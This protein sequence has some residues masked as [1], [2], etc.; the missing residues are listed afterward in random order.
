MKITRIKACNLASLAGVVE[1]DLKKGALA[2]AGLFAITGPTGSGKT[3]LLDA[4][5]LAL[6]DQTPRLQEANGRVK[7]GRAG[8]HDALSAQSPRSLLRHDAGSGYAEVDFESSE[9][10]PFCA[11][12]EVRRAGDKAS[13]RLQS[14]KMTLTDLITNEVMGSGTKTDTKNLI[15][16]HLGLN[17]DQ[18]TRSALLAQGQFASFLKAKRDERA[19]L[20]ER[21]TGTDLYARISEQAFA[22]NKAAKETL[23]T[24]ESRQAEL[25]LLTP[26]ERAAKHGILQEI[27]R[28]VEALERRQL[29]HKRHAEWT[30]RLAECSK[31][32][33]EAKA[34]AEAA[35]QAWDQGSEERARLERYE[36]AALQL[37][38]LAQ[39]KATQAKLQ[40]QGLQLASRRE[41]LKKAELAVAANETTLKSTL[42]ERTAARSRAEDLGPKIQRAQE[43]QGL[44]LAAKSEQ[45]DAQ[46]QL[47]ESSTQLRGA[48]REFSVLQDSV[49]EVQTQLRL[50]QDALAQ[51]AQAGSL[52]PI[53]PRVRKDLERAAALK[54]RLISVMGLQ[55]RLVALQTKAAE[56]KLALGTARTALD[57]ARKGLREHALAAPEGMDS[58]RA[59]L[60]ALE[61]RALRVQAQDKV[62]ADL[63]R[64]LTDLVEETQIH[65]SKRERLRQEEADLA[66]ALP[67]AEGAAQDSTR[68]RELGASTLDLQQHRHLLI[69]GHACPLCGSPE[70]PGV[71]PSSVVLGALEQQERSSREALEALRL[72]LHKCTLAKNECLRAQQSLQKKRL[73]LEAEMAQAKLTHSKLLEGFSDAPALSAHIQAQRS[74][75]TEEEQAYSTWRAQNEALELKQREAEGALHAREQLA[76]QTRAELDALKDQAL[77]LAKDTQAWELIQARLRE[78]LRELPG[79]LLQRLEQSPKTLLEDWQHRV[80]AA[81]AHHQAL[82]EGAEKAQTLQV[83]LASAKAKQS[84]ASGSQALAEALLLKRSQSLNALREAQLVLGIPDPE[85]AA[86]SLRDTVAAAEQ[87]FEHAA[88]HDRDLRSALALSTQ[89]LRTAADS[90]QLLTQELEELQRALQLSMGELSMEALQQLHAWDLAERQAAQAR[91]TESKE[92][93]HTTAAI[94]RLRAAEQLRL[95]SAEPEKLSID[96]LLPPL[97]SRLKETRTRFVALELELK[98][99]AKKEGQSQSLITEIAE[100]QEANHRWAVLS[101]MIGSADGDRFRQFAQGLTLESLLAHANSHLKELA[102]RYLLARV[103]GEDLELQIVDQAMAGEVRSVNSLSGGETFLTSLALALGLASLSASQT[104]VRTLFIDEGFGSLDPKS[105]DT[106]LATLDAL[107]AGGRQVGIISHVAGIGD[108]IGVQV[109]I[110]PIAPGKSQ[111][112]VP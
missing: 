65:Q 16:E 8:Q 11:R 20:L 22:K 29:A 98:E 106:A 18:F 52:A 10:R 56:A 101:A 64:Q 68:L 104:P 105:L 110:K 94:L 48:D 75:L 73:P 87:A 102:P 80:P 72:S 51:D 53:W 55:V 69:P 96:P 108:H 21:M 6:F 89:S 58:L 91:R 61:G 100:H 77:T 9:G 57:L 49:L 111:V 27:G 76:T 82:L 85:S 79:F 40:I 66:A 36:R 63:R 78:D 41:E 95:A 34:R 33:K 4:V 7:I 86:A 103:P 90:T 5:C 74:R 13:G 31:E 23:Q 67:A 60:I 44:A 26:L 12:W 50:A 2:Q 88:A 39:L 83:A 62:L 1:L 17:F 70:H 112:L 93:L 109:R 92:A 42:L 25:S 59:A 81:Q 45:D 24:L 99:Q 47:Q 28:E 15:V 35:E 37:E 43:L 54:E 19:E 32:L 84:S 46:K 97:E 38:R 71:D 30:E 107:Q 3:T 14:Q